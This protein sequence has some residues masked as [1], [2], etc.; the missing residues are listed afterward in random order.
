MQYI[1][2]GLRIKYNT[3]D[4][5]GVTS[6]TGVSSLKIGGKSIRHKCTNLTFGSGQTLHSWAGISGQE[7]STNDIVKKIERR[8]IVKGRW[9]SAK[10]LVIDECMRS[11]TSF[12]EL[13]THALQ[14]L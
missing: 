13:L 7:K 4:D 12:I 9:L 11:C 2:Q 8:D 6:S 1:I 14:C 3:L 10:A 5:V